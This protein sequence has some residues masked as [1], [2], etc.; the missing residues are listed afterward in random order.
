MQAAFLDLSKA[1]DRVSIPGLL[2]KLSAVG[3]SPELLKW[4]SSFLQ[5]KTQ[6]VEV[7]NC[8]SSWRVPISDIPQG[9]VLGPTLFLIYINDLP[10]CLVEESSIFADDTSVYTIG[11]SFPTTSDRLSQDLSRASNWASA[12]GML[13]NADKSA[14]LPIKNINNT[15]EGILVE[16]DGTR[17]PKVSHHRHLGVILNS[18]LSWSD[19]INSI[20]T[21]C[22]Q[23]IGILGRLR[24][25][26]SPNVVK[27]FFTAAIRPKFGVC[28]CNLV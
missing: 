25:T 8:L 20:Y 14:H 27:R 15:L 19:H 6:S 1:Y 16:M 13:F 2:Y 18:R 17:V 9:T 12:W 24:Y 28:L 21:A 10:D 11:D 5:G 3:V 23:K 22:A 4:L 26:L 7:G